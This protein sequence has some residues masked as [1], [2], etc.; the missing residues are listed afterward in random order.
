MDRNKIIYLYLRCRNQTAT[1]AEQE[2]FRLMLADPKTEDVLHDFWNAYWPED[3]FDDAYVE[4]ARYEEIFEEISAKPKLRRSIRWPQIAAA[5]M[6]LLMAAAGWFYTREN[7]WKKTTAEAVAKNDIVPGGN[8][9]YL[10]LANGKK[11]TLTDAVNGTLASQSGVQITKAAD[12]KLVYTALPQKSATAASAH[13]TIETPKGG[14]YQISLPDGS[15]VWLN[16][17]SRLS[18]PVSFAAQRERTVELNGEAYFEVAKDKDHPFQVKSGGQV[19]RV[20][21]THFN[22]NSYQDEEAVKTTLLEGA[23][24][25]LP[26]SGQLKSMVLKPGQQSVLTAA[27]LQVKTVEVNDVVDWKNGEFIFDNEPLPGIMRK[28][29]RWYNIEVEYR[30]PQSRQN[31]FTGSVSKSDKIGSI[32]KMLEKTSKLRFTVAGSKIIVD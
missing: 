25:V 8:K 13:N 20:L 17:D 4:V 14:Q 15:R 11:I 23:V 2:D 27:A 3:P 32:L 29:A 21:G 12:G 26:L 6:V 9:A 31:T 5:A 24:E 18:Y 10:T 30:N 22:I 28:V 16:T 19:I 1:A 7:I